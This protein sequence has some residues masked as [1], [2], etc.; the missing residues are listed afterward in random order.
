[1]VPELSLRGLPR[2]FPRCGLGK[3]KTPGMQISLRAERAYACEARFSCELTFNS[4]SKYNFNSNFN[5]S[6]VQF[7]KRRMRLLGL[8]NLVINIFFSSEVHIG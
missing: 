6:S 4:Q 3:Y 5:F 8:V 2:S 7:S 1:M